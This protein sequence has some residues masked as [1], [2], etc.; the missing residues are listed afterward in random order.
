MGKCDGYEP[1]LT[2]EQA[3]EKEQKGILQDK[4]FMFH[5]SN[6]V[7]FQTSGGIKSLAANGLNQDDAF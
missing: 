1:N 3:L 6:D 2:M 7:E 4:F 5:I